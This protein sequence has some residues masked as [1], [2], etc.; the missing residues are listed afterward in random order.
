LL[1]VTRL[2]QDGKLHATIKFSQ[3]KRM[4]SPAIPPAPDGHSEPLNLPSPKVLNFA[5]AIELLDN[6][7]A[8]YLEAVRGYFQDIA[9]LPAR[10]D[11]LLSKADLQE[12]IRAL[13][14]CK[15]ASLT[16]GANVLSELCRQ[17]EVTLKALRKNQQALDESTR[18]TMYL[19]LENAVANTRQAI[20]EVLG[21]LG[22]QNSAKTNPVL[23]T[24]ALVEDLISLR[25]LLAR[26]DMRA[27][28]RHKAICALHT[29]ASAQLQTLAPAIKVF[30]F[31]KAV[32]QC[33]ELI[34]DFSAPKLT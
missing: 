17:F 13:H 6:S 5:A 21:S 24:R 11:N 9:N 34:S 23:N 27:L 8:L 30:N 4:N 28:A 26:S 16:V 3:I 7:T 15:G 32:V 20:T 10:M 18:Q 12:A 14:T 29:S 33:D 31:A 2:H 25:N 1:A 19:A 22:T